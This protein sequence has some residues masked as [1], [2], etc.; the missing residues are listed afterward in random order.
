MLRLSGKISGARHALDRLIRSN[1]S[2]YISP[3]VIAQ[4]Y[5]AL[6]ENDLAFEWLSKAV[7][8][9]DP[10]VA[11]LGLDAAFD[12]LHSDPRYHGLRKKVGLEEQ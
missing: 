8:Q 5:A 9:H 12:A 7:E 4:N 6:R 1:S 3:F 10:D 11:S 2:A